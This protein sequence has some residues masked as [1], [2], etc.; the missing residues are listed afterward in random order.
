VRGGWIWILRASGG[1]SRR[2][3]AGAVPAWSPDGT[4]IAYIAPGGWVGIIA[5]RGG[6][7]RLLHARARALDWQPLPAHPRR[8]CS[9]PRGWTFVAGNAQ[10]VVASTSHPSAGSYFGGWYGCLRGLG[11]W[12]L[13]LAGTADYA[14]YYT[15]VSAVRLAGRFALVNSVY[16]DKYQNCGL[17]MDLGDLAS[18]R[19]TQLSGQPCGYGVGAGHSLDSP[20]LDS[21]GFAAWRV[22]T[23]VPPSQS[24]SAV[25]CPSISACVA[26][27]DVGIVASSTNPTGGRPAWELDHTPATT[28]NSVSCPTATFCAAAASTG[29]EVLTSNDPTDPAPQWNAVSADGSANA[30]FPASAISCPSTSLCIE[31]DGSGNIVASTDPAAAAPNWNS[32]HVLGG[33]PPEFSAIDCPSASLCVATDVHGDIVTSTNPT[34]DAS[35]WNVASVDPTTPWT[36]PGGVSCPSTTLCVAV[37]GTANVLSSTEPTGG[38][39]A[40]KVT[41]SRAGGLTA[42]SCPTIS[43]CVATDGQ[44][45][46]ITSTDPTGGT[47]AWQLSKIDGTN[48]INGISCPSVAECVA[49]DSN[50][51]VLTSNSPTAGPGAWSSAPVDVPDCAIQGTRCLVEQLEAR[52]DHGTHV[53]D[54]TA[55]GNGNSIKN[56]VLTPNGLDL[57]WTHDGASGQATLG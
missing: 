11:K 27:D 38:A 28:L 12:H 51:T 9:L 56:V 4:R 5:A 48:R 50:G 13:L 7:P 16:S 49:V 46:V 57:S 53:L 1:R 41:P 20:V 43:L 45:D 24:L 10:D 19:T 42:I 25:S 36:L 54:T 34:G 55:P 39:S 2:L 40:W 6:R 14:G 52:D 8:S 31:A 23:P 17:I 33:A 29:S 22:V 18:G 35:A 30:I 32:V 3:V 44:G 26:V 15:T 21:S 37:D 47:A